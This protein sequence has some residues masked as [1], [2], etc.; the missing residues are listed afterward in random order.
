M[1]KHGGDQGGRPK[2]SEIEVDIDEMMKW[3]RA[4]CTQKEI[5]QKLGISWPTLMDRLSR[6]EYKGAYE[7]AQGEMIIS[8]RSKQVAMA[9]G[10]NVTMLIWLGKQYLGQRDQF[11]HSGTGPNGEIVVSEAK[12]ALKAEFDAIHAKLAGTDSSTPGSRPN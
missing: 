3:A 4:G 5:A 2:G 12:A 7:R 6:P 10:G 8:L 1:P 11:V 9:L